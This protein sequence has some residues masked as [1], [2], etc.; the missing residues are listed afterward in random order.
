M[1]EVHFIGTP[2]LLGAEQTVFGD[3]AKRHP[4]KLLSARGCVLMC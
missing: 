4:L 1:D 3:I 2:I